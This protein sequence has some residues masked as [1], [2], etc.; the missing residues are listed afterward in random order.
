MAIFE[1]IV[2]ASLGESYPWELGYDY[3]ECRVHFRENILDVHAYAG[4][5]KLNRT[6]GVIILEINAFN[7]LCK[8]DY[9]NS[10]TEHREFWSTGLLNSCAKLLE[11]GTLCFARLRCQSLTTSD[12]C[13]SSLKLNSQLLSSYIVEPLINYYY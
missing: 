5:R 2:L 4:Y 13:H 1:F 7:S 8:Q 11:L 9:W 10:R 3:A 6:S 12:F